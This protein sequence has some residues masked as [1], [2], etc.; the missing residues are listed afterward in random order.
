MRLGLR[1]NNPIKNGRVSTQTIQRKMIQFRSFCKK[2]PVWRLKCDMQ[3]FFSHASVS[4]LH[5]TRENWRRN[6][7]EEI[8]GDNCA[9]QNAL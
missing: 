3:S 4:K 1:M 7:D 8:T 9:N 5:G 6:S 2:A